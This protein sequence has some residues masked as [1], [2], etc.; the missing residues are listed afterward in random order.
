MPRNHLEPR[1]LMKTW[2]VRHAGLSHAAALLCLPRAPGEEQAAFLSF[3]VQQLL[4]LMS[5]PWCCS[6]FLITSQ[7]ATCSTMG[8]SPARDAAT[9]T[10]QGS[11]DNPEFMLLQHFLDSPDSVRLCFLSTRGEEDQPLRRK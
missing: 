2:L 5:F 6:G 10:L 9:L 11:G 8:F 3:L 1:S 4:H 7:V